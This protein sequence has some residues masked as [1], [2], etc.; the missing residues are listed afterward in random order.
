[1]FVLCFF[2]LW[3]W[4]LALK[5][6]TTI[7]FWGEKSQQNNPQTAGAQKFNTNNYLQ[8]LEQIFGTQSILAILTPTFAKM[9]HDGVQWTRNTGDLE[10]G[11]R[12]ETVGVITVTT[13]A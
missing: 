11:S 5:G 7:E 2:N 8:N 12:E 3:N 1:M 6:A 10:S 9:K 13:K 4:Y